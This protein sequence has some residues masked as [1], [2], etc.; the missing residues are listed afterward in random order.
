VPS[1]T[2]LQR[3]PQYFGKKSP[4]FDVASG[5]FGQFI[6]AAFHLKTQRIH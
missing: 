6:N 1:T 4:R 2:G 5:Q 3:S